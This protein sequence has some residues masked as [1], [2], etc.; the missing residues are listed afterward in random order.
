MRC[1]KLFVLAAVFVLG[2]CGP[3]DS[4]KQEIAEKKRIECLDK[5]CE[6]DVEPTRRIASEVALKLYGQWYIAPKYY[7]STGMNGAAFYW[8]SRK[9]REDVPQNERVDAYAHTVE[10]LLTGRQRW[11]DPHF[12]MPWKGESWEARFSELQ[13]QGL[14]IERQTLRPEL[15][16]IRFFDAQGHQYRLEYYLATQQRKV[17]GDGVPG[18]ACDLPDQKPRALPRCTGGVFWQEDI[19]ADFRF[20][21]QHAADWPAIHQEIVRI[22]NLAKKVQP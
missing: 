8:P 19:Y 14:R 20:H 11:P 16:R 4:Q 2:A 17:R 22:L 15:E 18:V 12:K 6:G 10:I 13:K 9:N 21:A 3:N 7:Y 5:F 1:V